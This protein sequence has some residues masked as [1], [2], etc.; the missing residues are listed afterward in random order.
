MA[1][2]NVIE[3]E[4]K[5]KQKKLQLKKMISDCIKKSIKQYK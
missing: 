3:K 5:V 2:F 1:S 4:L